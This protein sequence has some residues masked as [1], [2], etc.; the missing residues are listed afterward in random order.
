MPEITPVIV[1][2]GYVGRSLASC[3]GV[4]PIGTAEALESPAIPAAPLVILAGGIKALALCERDPQRAAQKNLLEPAAIARRAGGI[5]VYISTDYVFDGRRGGY[6]ATDAPNP[7][8]A[9]GV[10]KVRGEDAILSCPRGLVV[11]TAHLVGDGCP[12]VSWLVQQ[13]ATGETV[14]AW[15]DRFNTPTPVQLLADGIIQAAAAG[16]TGV[17]HVCGRR[18]V[19]RVALFRDIAAMH[20]LDE[21][22]IEPGW[23]EDPLVP[24]DIS[25]VTG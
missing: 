22:L 14:R 15:A 17:I 21:T 23:C 11:R 12:W 3:L 6:C 24:A 2:R 16:T 19:N 13:L 25:L 4:L 20:G 5:V 18:R 8:T 7:K 10:S 1:G 9:Y